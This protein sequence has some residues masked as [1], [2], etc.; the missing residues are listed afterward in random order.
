MTSTLK[1][2]CTIINKLFQEPNFF[3][4]LC[5]LS[6]N[7]I[8][9][10]IKNI[11][12]I[13]N[14]YLSTQD[15]IYTYPL[16]EL[17]V[18]AKQTPTLEGII[19]HPSNSIEENKYNFFG[20]NSTSILQD[21]RIIELETLEQQV[22]F[23][24]KSTFFYCAQI[25]DDIKEAI[26]LSHSSPYIVYK[27]ILK[28]PNQKE[29]PIVV[30]TKETSYYQSILEIRLKNVN[31][32]YRKT[33]SK[34]AKRILK[35][36]IGKDSLLVI[37]PKQ[38]KRYTIQDKDISRQETPIHIPSKYLSFIKIPSRYK[39]LSICSTNKN[40]RNGELININTGL[41]YESID[42]IEEP[43]YHVYYS[44]YEFI[45]ITDNFEYT[46][47]EFTQDISYDIDLIYGNLDT[48]HSR[49]KVQ[50][51]P[52]KNIDF[53][54]T[55]EDIHVR[56]LNGKYHIR[57]GR[58]RILYLKY[59]Y[60]SNY[61]AYQEMNS[62]DKLKQLVTIPAS[63][64]RTIENQSVNN[65]ISKIKELSSKTLFLKTNINNE[66]PGLI[67]IFEDKTY[68]TNTEQE[69]N[70]LYNLLSQN[71]I[72]NKF[73]IGYNSSQYKIDYEELFD[74]LIITLKE[75]IYD[76]SLTDIIDYLL[77]QGFYQKDKYFLVS[78]LNYF[79]LYFEYVDL[80]HYI[81]IKRLF[82]K[83][84]NIVEEIEEKLSKKEIGEEILN[85]IK[86]NPDLIELDWK[87]FYS[88]L[89]AM[90]QFKSYSLEFLE[91]AA[92]YAGYQKE[93]LLNFY[94]NEI[95]TKKKRL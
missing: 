85:I 33:V 62:L 70:E 60:I 29:I 87:E 28:Q 8:E 45:N 6:N 84:I 53:I 68:I 4:Y 41:P 18:I 61:Q 27:S 67:I 49:E 12:L 50:R 66:E 47:S 91:S 44:R 13:I 80:Q 51:D 81:Q 64:E 56:K 79:Y 76:M 42:S 2:S 26:D 21:S 16:Q 34:K 10:V 69:L 65:T 14:Y 83:N 57:N 7:D 46:N 20:L 77:T 3:E 17:L 43:T 88:I 32:L 31:D 58:H 38:T 78:N 54:K 36:Y 37:F 92:N 75:K 59:F 73:F 86:D 48:N 95:C 30:G 25:T 35:R 63:V 71:N 89:S 90:D 22:S 15:N 24:N 40:L 93:R 55:K 1:H 39:L 11:S 23:T 5:K 74:Y 82:R 94:N 52:Y 72:Y 9:E 19:I